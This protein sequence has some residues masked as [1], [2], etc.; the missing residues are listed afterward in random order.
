MGKDVSV[1][2]LLD[3]YDTVVL[4]YGCEEEKRLIIPGCDLK[5]NI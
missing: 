3:F 2:E 4:S 5:V 1:K